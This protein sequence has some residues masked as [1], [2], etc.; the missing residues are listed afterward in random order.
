MITFKTCA[1]GSVLA[2]ATLLAVAGCSREA[3]KASR[4]LAE[5]TAASAPRGEAGGQIERVSR[6]YRDQAVPAERRSYADRTDSAAPSEP[7]RLGWALSR[8]GGADDNARRQFERN[9]ADFAAASV[10]DYVAKARSFAESPPKGALSAVRANG[11]RLYYDPRSNTFMVADRRGAPRTMFKPR[12][13]RAYWTQQQQ[14][15]AE[16]GSQQRSYRES[17]SARDDA[18]G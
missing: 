5:D 9:G 1:A 12:E 10:Q 13:G 16:G 17:G 2:A 6:S 14:R 7:S 18:A 11:D 3:D 15:L 4:N 8:R